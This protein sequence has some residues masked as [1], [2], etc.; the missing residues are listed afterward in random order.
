MEKLEQAEMALIT[1]IDGFMEV[2]KDVEA[3]VARTET[4]KATLEATCDM[5]GE[6]ADELRGE[7]V[8]LAKERDGVSGQINGLHDEYKKKRAVEEAAC[9]KERQ[10]ME[11]DTEKFE[12]ELADRRELARGKWQ[13]VEKEWDTAKKRLEA[14]NRQLSAVAASIT[15]R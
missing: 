10:K 2:T 15:N 12:Q 5:L 14:V 7:L 9:V 1:A 6:K 13:E 3:M 11:A 8:A 4:T